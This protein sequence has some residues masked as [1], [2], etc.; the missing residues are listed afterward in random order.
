MTIAR[1]NG[2]DII[3]EK[4]RGGY[5]CEFLL[6]RGQE[7]KTEEKSE[8]ENKIKSNKNNKKNITF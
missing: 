1:E 8:Y 4:Y 3:M 7:I 5:I 2:Y 6:L